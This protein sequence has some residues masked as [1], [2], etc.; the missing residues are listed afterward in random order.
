MR[1]MVYPYAV[2][3]NPWHGCDSL[4]PSTMR[5]TLRRKTAAVATPHPAAADAGRELLQR[6]GNAVDAA[7]GAMLACCVAMPGSVGLGGYGGS[8]VAY[9]ASPVA[10]APGGT[11]V[12]ID[13]DSRAPVA[14][15]PE[16][17][18][19][20]QKYDL[21]YLS[22]TVPAIVAGLD[23]ALQ[24]F[25]TLPWVVVSEPAIALAEQG[26][27]V[28]AELKLQLDNWARKAD[29]V[30]LRGLFPRGAVP[31]EG[32]L[33]AQR[34]L[35]K[36]LR[37]LAEE[38][39]GA[40]YRGDIPRAIVQQ[41]RDHGGIL[42]EEDF[43]R[44]R[45][46]IVKPLGINYR[47][48]RVLTPP[49]PSGGLTSLQI[50]KTLEQFDLSKLHPWGA[51]YFH[52][53]AEAA[54]MAWQDRVRYVGDPDVTPIPV[55]RLLSDETARTN[56]AQI[57][58]GQIMRADGTM[59][60]SPLH[61]VNI[62]AADALGNVV[63][64]TATHG[65]LYGS[66]VVIDGLGLVMGH[67]MSRFDLAPNGPNTPAAGKRMSHNMAPAVLLGRDGRAC[68]AVGLPGGTKIVTVTAQLVVSLLDFQAA[69]ALAV[70][71]GRVH[72]EA[73]EPVSVSSA[74]PDSVVEDLQALRH[75]VRRGQDVGGPPGEIG[76]PA[77]A[78]VIDPHTGEVSAAS[79][80]GE[81]A[82][83]TVDV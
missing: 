29:P 26:V 72:A 73:G 43:E 69:P 61:T 47:G 66:A 17:F 78:L 11:V 51:D 57:Q 8:M 39:P 1:D 12:A 3:Q 68:A 6:G 7:V 44:Y 80:A 65:H 53:I 83:V 27:P 71:A 49:P 13:F 10:S 70:H 36:L 15:Q 21:G 64:L 74:V 48:Y 59:P 30:S 25:G 81:D 33:W 82:A 54:K 56:A 24:R 42:T 67:G 32:A 20:R 28:T 9:L 52:L 55:E 14:Y 77:N 23:L 38:G 35:A 18:S 41:V 37:R 79:Q 31:K 40:F 22:I 76:G 16:R 5:T 50:L 60:P 19:D 2:P 75:T 63:S 58:R 62:L 4:N 34:D 46:A 45:P